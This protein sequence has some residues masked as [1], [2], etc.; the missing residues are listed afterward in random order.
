MPI[1]RNYIKKLEFE[2]RALVAQQ[3]EFEARQVELEARILEL[4]VHLALPKFQ[5]DTTIQTQD[6]RNWLD[7]VEAN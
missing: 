6:V 7:Y 5:H 2:N 1:P 4:R 3:A